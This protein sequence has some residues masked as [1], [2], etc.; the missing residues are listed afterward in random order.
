MWPAA[1]SVSLRAAGLFL[2]KIK[3]KML[4]ILLALTT[5]A[6]AQDFM[7]SSPF[8]MGQPLPQTIRLH[9]G[10]Q[11]IGTGT[12]THYPNEVR[13]VIRLNNGELLGTQVLERN[14]KKTFYDVNGVESAPPTFKYEE[15][16]VK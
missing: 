10:H 6:S 14:G 4:I 13:I 2:G 7:L 16:E 11:I 12:V 3:M 5:A 1:G 8:R 15:P 9:D